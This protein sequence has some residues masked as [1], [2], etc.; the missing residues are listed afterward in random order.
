MTDATIRLPVSVTKNPGR[1]SGWTA[2]YGQYPPIQ[3]RGATAA[4]ARA[5]LADALAVALDAITRNSPSFHRDDQGG[6]WVAVPA[7]DGGSHSWRVTDEGARQTGSSNSPPAEA[8]AR[9]V[10]MTPV[11]AR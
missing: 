3:A 10:G 8:H 7:A 4:E 9:A 5:A 1:R 11:P 6:L 2:A